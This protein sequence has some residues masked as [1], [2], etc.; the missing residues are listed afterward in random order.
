MFKS[1]INSISEP[2]LECIKK[3]KAKCDALFSDCSLDSKTILQKC[4][5]ELPSILNDYKTIISSLL[6]RKIPDAQYDRIIEGTLYKN[7]KELI[8]KQNDV[9][10][11]LQNTSAFCKI[12]SQIVDF[13]NRNDFSQSS[14]LVLDSFNKTF[15][16][17]LIDS[18][19]MINDI[20]IYLFKSDLTFGWKRKCQD[21]F[22]MWQS[23][24]QALYTKGSGLCFGDKEYEGAAIAMIRTSIENKI[25]RAF[26]IFGIIDAQRN[27][28][29]CTFDLS[30]IFDY[31]KPYYNNKNITFIIS[32]PNI[33]R[34]NGWTNLY[35]HSGRID[36]SWL[37]Y[38]VFDYLTPLFVGEEGSAET[39]FSLY[40][41]IK[42]KH[43]IITKIWN[44]I[45]ADINRSNPKNLLE[46][47]KEIFKRKTHKKKNRYTLYKY[48]NENELEAVLF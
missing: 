17:F 31:I 14:D 34:I 37:S 13:L 4:V 43:G 8:N 7:E 19:F 38:I 24:R 41:G 22:Q 1:K 5:T 33:E 16:S 44:D 21:T 36:Y 15:E 28:A 10:F 18:Y 25:R 23:L 35:L 32:L 20:A 46:R 11:Y 6:S 30:R 26:G 47:I 12:V 3:Y 2:Q 29:F 40:S 27:D 42:I 45:E 39:G 9:N 48:E